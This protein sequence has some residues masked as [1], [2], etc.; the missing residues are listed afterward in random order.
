MLNIESKKYSYS[1][2]GYSDE[3]TYYYTYTYVNAHN[4][5]SLCKNLPMTSKKPARKL[6][7]FSR[8]LRTPGPTRYIVYYFAFT[9]LKDEKIG[10]PRNVRSDENKPT[11]AYEMKRAKWPID[12]K[13]KLHNHN[14]LLAE[15]TKFCISRSQN[16]GLRGQKNFKHGNRNMR[17]DGVKI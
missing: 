17:R 1:T 9:I 10:F 11:R 13:T 14:K 15:V 16:C 5:L 8:F 6:R 2:A 3:Y 12:V 4:R 7:I